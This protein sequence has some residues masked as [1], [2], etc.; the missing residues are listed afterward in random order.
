MRWC[1]IEAREVARFPRYSRNLLLNLIALSGEEAVF[2]ALHL[3]ALEREGEPFTKRGEEAFIA[4]GG[5]LL[6]KQ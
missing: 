2:W 4:E 3:F 5:I 6:P 1:S